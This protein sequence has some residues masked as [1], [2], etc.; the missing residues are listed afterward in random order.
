MH[1]DWNDVVAEARKRCRARRARV[2]A[3]PQIAAK[4]TQP[5]LRYRD[6]SFWTGYIPPKIIEGPSGPIENRSPERRALIEICNEVIEAERQAAAGGEIQTA[7]SPGSVTGPQLTRLHIMF[8]EAQITERADK[9]DYCQVQTGRPIEST[10]QL[11]Q[12][13]ASIVMDM[14]AAIIEMEKQA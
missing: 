14:L 1:E 2:L 10:K 6:P 3:H 13:E 5:P 11:S 4:L 9:L 7:A 8:A 12:N